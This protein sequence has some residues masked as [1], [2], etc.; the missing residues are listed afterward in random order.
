M[1]TGQ[2]ANTPN[3]AIN[4]LY[5]AHVE[6]CNVYLHNLK[7][8][9]LDEMILARDRQLNFSSLKVVLRLPI[10]WMTGYYKL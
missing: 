7:N 2:Y 4:R 5:S 1:F 9:V 6:A 10:V 3:V 8:I